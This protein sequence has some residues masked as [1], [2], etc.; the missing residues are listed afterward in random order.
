MLVTLYISKL[1]VAGTIFLGGSLLLGIL[2]LLRAIDF[3]L[4]KTVEQAKNLAS[5]AI[6]YLPALFIFLFIDKCNILYRI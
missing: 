5:A 6:L 4:H 1:N 3:Y 2:L